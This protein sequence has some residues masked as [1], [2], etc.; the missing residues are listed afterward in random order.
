MILALTDASG[1]LGAA[2]GIVGAASIVVCV[3]LA[4]VLSRFRQPSLIVS[5][6]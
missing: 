4:I 3:V 1:T 5:A 6:A 2:I